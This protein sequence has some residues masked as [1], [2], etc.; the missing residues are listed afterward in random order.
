VTGA[1]SRFEGHAA[2]WDRVDRAGDVFRAGAFG[3]ARTVPL[4]WQ[5][6]GGP[7]GVADV[8]ED[9]TGLRI[10]G[11]LTDAG[12]AALVRDG[13]LRGLSVGYRPLVAARGRVRELLRVELVEVSLVAV[14]MQ[15]AARI[16]RVFQEE[17]I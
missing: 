5:H 1:A 15:P 10:V 8:H 6:R 14:P 12:L 16:D 13:R 9:A 4:L 7:V 3:P 11:R 2:L 17:T